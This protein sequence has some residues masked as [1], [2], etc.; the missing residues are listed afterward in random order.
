[1]V[2]FSGSVFDGAIEGHEKVLPSA[3]LLAV[4]YSLDEPEQLFVICQ[5]YKLVSSQLSFKKV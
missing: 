4:R 1:M 5:D 2:V 3:E